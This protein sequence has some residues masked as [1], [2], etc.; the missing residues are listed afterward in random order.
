MQ[1][2][3]AGRRAGVFLYL[4]REVGSSCKLGEGEGEGMGEG[5]GRTNWFAKEVANEATI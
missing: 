2:S 1:R 4:S 5:V 3:T